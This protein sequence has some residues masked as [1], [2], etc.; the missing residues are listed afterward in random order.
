MSVQSLVEI[1]GC[2]V[3]RDENDGVF[4]FF[5]Y[6]CVFAMLFKIGLACMP[7]LACDSASAYQISLELDDP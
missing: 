7:L 2:T 6:I 5:L 4:L 3:T 1:G